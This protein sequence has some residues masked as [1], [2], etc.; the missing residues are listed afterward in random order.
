MKVSEQSDTLE[1][2]SGKFKFYSNTFDD[3]KNKMKAMEKSSKD[4]AKD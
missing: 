4:S 2:Y 3:L 1:D